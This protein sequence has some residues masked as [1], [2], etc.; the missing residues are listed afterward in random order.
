M[1]QTI[2]KIQTACGVIDYLDSF[3]EKTLQESYKKVN[4]N[5]K[6]ITMVASDSAESFFGRVPVVN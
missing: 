1:I 6:M 5:G 4:V 2:N 3:S